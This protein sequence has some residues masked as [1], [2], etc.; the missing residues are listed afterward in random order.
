M[1]RVGSQRQSKK[2]K[3][4]ISF[5]FIFCSGCVGDTRVLSTYSLFRAG[6]KASKSVPAYFVFEKQMSMSAYN[7]FCQVR[8]SNMLIF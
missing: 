6:D 7:L 4:V 8:R 2:K 5:S 1:T 3:S